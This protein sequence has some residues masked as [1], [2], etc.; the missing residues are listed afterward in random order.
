MPAITRRGGDLLLKLPTRDRTLGARGVGGANNIRYNPR[1]ALSVV[2]PSN[3]YR[4]AALQGR[5][6]EVRPDE[7]CVSTDPIA[8]LLLST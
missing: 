6:T 7:A 2:D 3:P 1:V 8:L 4:M 5:L